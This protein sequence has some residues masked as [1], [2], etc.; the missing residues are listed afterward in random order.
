MLMAK[1]A[2]C[3]FSVAVSLELGPDSMMLARSVFRVLLRCSRKG[4]QV[5]GKASSQGVA[6]PTL[7]TPWPGK[8]RA[9]F[10]GV[11]V[12]VEARL[13]CCDKL[14]GYFDFV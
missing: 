9:V 7:C 11:V 6:I 13:A 14:D 4:L 10:G 1:M 2:G 3:A 8:K 12:V 5:R